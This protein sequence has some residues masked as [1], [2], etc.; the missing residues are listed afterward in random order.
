M[1]NLLHRI[2]KIRL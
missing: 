1:Q 2:H